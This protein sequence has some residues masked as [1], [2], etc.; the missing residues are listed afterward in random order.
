MAGNELLQNSIKTG[1][2]RYAV[3]HLH[4]R[5]LIEEKDSYMNP[6]ELKFQSN[7]LFAIPTLDTT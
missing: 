4:D 3:T 6:F 7:A 2:Y 5:I 1:C